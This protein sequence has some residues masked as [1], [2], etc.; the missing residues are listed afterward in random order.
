MKDKIPKKEKP[1]IADIKCTMC[2][3]KFDIWDISLGDNQYDIFVNY[4]SKHDLKRLKFNFCVN[5]FDKVLDMI[6]PMCKL[7]P[8]AEEDLVDAVRKNSDGS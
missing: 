4:P 1:K 5:C 6:I 7:N 8:V 2:G 3:K